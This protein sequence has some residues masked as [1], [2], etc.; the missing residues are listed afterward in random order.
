M[1]CSFHSRTLTNDLTRFFLFSIIID[2]RLKRFPKLLFQLAWDPRYIA[3]GQIQQ[4]TQFPS[5]SQYLDCCLLIR[6]RGNVFT[7]SLL[8]SELLL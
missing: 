4:K 1:K 8:S 2:C 3:L 7:E 5:L 6:C